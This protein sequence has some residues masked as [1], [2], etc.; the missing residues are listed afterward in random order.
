MNGEHMEGW[1]GRGTDGRME[2]RRMAGWMDEGWMG[3]GWIYLTMRCRGI[4]R[5]D[6]GLEEW[7][8]G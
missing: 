7:I 2:K 3:D 5:V 4:R 1:S 8:N 6:G